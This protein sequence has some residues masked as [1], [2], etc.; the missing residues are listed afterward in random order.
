MS[1]P[2]IRQGSP[3]SLRKMK[4]FKKVGTFLGEPTFSHGFYIPPVKRDCWERGS[5]NPQ[6]RRK[7]RY[8]LTSGFFH[9]QKIQFSFLPER[10]RSLTK[11]QREKDLFSSGKLKFKFPTKV[12]GY[13]NA[14]PTEIR[15]LKPEFCP[16]YGPCY[17]YFYFNY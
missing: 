9:H 17:V 6:A 8:H 4:E 7:E 12:L 5:A 1:L 3:N 2:A 10:E 13:Q 15:I 16:A 14:P 11:R